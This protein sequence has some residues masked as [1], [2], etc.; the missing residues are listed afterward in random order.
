ML[1]ILSLTEP[2]EQTPLR[3]VSSSACGWD[4]FFTFY[5][6]TMTVG[7]FLKR[8]VDFLNDTYVSQCSSMSCLLDGQLPYLWQ[9]FLE[10]KQSGAALELVATLCSSRSISKV[11][12]SPVG[13]VVQE[14]P[15]SGDVLLVRRNVCYLPVTPSVTVD[16]VFFQKSI[17]FWSSS[18]RKW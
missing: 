17:L 5:R 10:H 8:S 6:S 15:L 16:V 1:C 12:G 18:K 2:S 13:Q 9:G 11:E 3:R 14:L 7:S 4:F